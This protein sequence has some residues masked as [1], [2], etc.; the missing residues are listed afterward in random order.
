[1]AVGVLESNSGGS[2]EG[3]SEGVR[4]ATARSAKRLVLVTQ[5]RRERGDWSRVVGTESRGDAG[6]RRGAPTLRRGQDRVGSKLTCLRNVGNA[7]GSW[8]V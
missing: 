1:M 3:G 8:S 4:L 5:V 7:E 2:V 6:A